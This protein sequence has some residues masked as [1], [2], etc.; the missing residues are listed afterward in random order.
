MERRLAAILM[1]DMVGYS[2]LMG[3]DE[4]GTIARQ[5]LHRDEIID[6]KISMHGG[7]I[8]N[9]TGD[10]LLVE[11]P[12]VVDA[13]KCAVEVQTELAD[14]DTDVPKSRRI[15]YRIGI[16]LGDVVVDGDDILGDGVNVAA[17][18]EGLA[19]PGGV[20]ISG[21]VHDHLSGKVPA[22]F[23][24]AGEQTVKNVLR[25]VRVWHWQPG[26]SASDHSNPDKLLSLPDKPSIAVLP[27]VNMSG[28][29]D[30]EH[31]ADGITEDIITELS[32]FRSLFVIARH[33]SFHYKGKSPRIP[34]VGRELGVAYV[35]EGSVRKAG[36]RVRITAQLIE[37]KG[38]KHLWAERYDRDLEDIFAVQ[39]EVASEIVTAVPGHVDIANRVDAERKPANDLSAYDLVLRS[40]TIFYRD[41]TSLQIKELLEKALEIDPG[42][43][44]AH[45]RLANFLAYSI[46]SH[47]FGYKETSSLA[48]KHADTALQL[49]PNDPVVQ[50]TVAETHMLI[51][52]H[53]TAR[54]HIEKAI[55]LNPND[56]NVM[57][58][59]GMSFAYLGDHEEGLK[60][61]RLAARRDP[62][63]SNS[64]REGFFDC[65]YLAGR[66]E[67][68]IEQTRG[69]RNPPPHIHAELA[70]AYA[71][72]GRMEEARAAAARFKQ[73]DPKGWE[74]TEM[75]QAHARMCAK[76]ADAER[77]LDGYRKAGVPV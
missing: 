69:W 22:V 56:Y 2:R 67:E 11:F 63:S 53:E 15:Q 47:L 72:L 70:A 10:G 58:L 65:Y 29:A 8:V 64:V 5:K 45:G 35:V 76:Q 44:R 6:P 49:D 61:T 77:W 7:R 62:Y 14:R 23:E 73:L 39:D 54:V 27:F 20:C 68:A 42:Y 66:Y 19:K 59:A 16:N 34:D 48:R 33:S 43:A 75:R 60:W 21:T 1:T 46:F 41:W 26:R 36:N 31:F 17:R 28:D 12:S 38:G 13:V 74:A 32:R 55:A 3:L 52:D 18:L 4:E 24:E 71:M 40:E 9:T 37:A 57:I 50:A 51:G 25:P 30:Q